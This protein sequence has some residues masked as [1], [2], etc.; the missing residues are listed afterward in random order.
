MLKTTLFSILLALTTI[1]T[2]RAQSLTL[3]IN[4]QNEDF[5]IFKGGLQ[6]GH[7]G[8]YYYIDKEIFEKECDS[9]KKTFKEGSSIEEYY[10][11]LRY[12]I[13]SLHHGHTRISL[14][15]N[16]NVNYK[17]AVLDSTKLYLPYE[18][19]IVNNQ[20]IIKED[21]SK[22]QLIPRF[23]IVKS[24]NNVSSKDLIQKMLPYISADGINQTF[25]YYSLYNYFYFHY[26]FNLFYPNKK[27]LKF[28]YQN[29]TTH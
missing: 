17:M 13:S 25:K 5:V 11:K 18:L 15:T 10:L 16:G 4:Q 28:E 24:I 29:N 8:L 9:I 20:L 21:C 1:S 26:L 14:S 22:E 19:L 7:S 6:E 12:I 23:S 2:V 27:G 3:T